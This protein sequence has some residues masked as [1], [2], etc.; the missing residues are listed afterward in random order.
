M[1]DPI[2]DRLASLPTLNKIALRE[3]GGSSANLAHPTRRGS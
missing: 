1:P 2:A 3:L